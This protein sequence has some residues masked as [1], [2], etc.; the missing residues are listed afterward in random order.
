MDR[1]AISEGVTV[2][3]ADCLDVL[4][5]AMSILHPGSPDPFGL[6]CMYT[7]IKNMQTL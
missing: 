1:E 2:D 6:L 7:G 4:T 5:P 3:G